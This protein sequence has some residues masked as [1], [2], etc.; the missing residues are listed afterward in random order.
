MSRLFHCLNS[1]LSQL[2]Y[3][4]PNYGLGET[5]LINIILSSNKPIG[6]NVTFKINLLEKRASKILVIV[7]PIVKIKEYKLK[8]D[9]VFNNCLLQLRDS[10]INRID[11]NFESFRT[12]K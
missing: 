6:S 12:T 3:I 1:F 8:S 9:Q 4:G 11:T 5:R 2:N 7:L 10:L